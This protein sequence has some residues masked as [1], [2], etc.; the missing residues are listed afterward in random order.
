MEAYYSSDDALRVRFLVMDIQ[1]EPEESNASKYRMDAHAARWTKHSFPVLSLTLIQVIE[2]RCNYISVFFIRHVFC[3]NYFR[4]MSFI[5][6]KRT[7]KIV[8]GTCYSGL[9][10]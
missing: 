8:R 10:N 7:G 6:T 5:I 1:M 3:I 4:I 9:G 2:S